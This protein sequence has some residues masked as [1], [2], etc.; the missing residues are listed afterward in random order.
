MQS[1]SHSDLKT[2]LLRLSILCALILLCVGARASE[3]AAPEAAPAAEHG[4]P[5]AEAKAGGEKGD[6]S[7][8]ADYNKLNNKMSSLKVKVEE[9]RKKLE[10]LVAKKKMGMTAVKD[11]KGHS[12]SI[13]E[14][15]VE[16]HKDYVEEA[17]KFESTLTEITYRFPGKGQEIRNNYHPLRAKSIQQVERELGLSGQLSDLRIK[18]QEKYK[19][20]NPP[21]PEA[22]PMPLT[23]RAPASEEKPTRLK[24][25]K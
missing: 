6:R 2:A 1:I 14:M 22:E 19:A 23:E 5:G 20:F 3:E 12:S 11:E 10:D 7:D 17:E 15:I 13:L 24:L 16:T 9:A 21:A 18:V 8:F 25:K 4:S